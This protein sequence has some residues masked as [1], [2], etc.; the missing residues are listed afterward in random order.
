MG[1]MSHALF[2]DRLTQDV[3]PDDARR[4][5][6]TRVR[7]TIILDLFTLFKLQIFPQIAAELAAVW[8]AWSYADKRQLLAWLFFCLCV[9]HPFEVWGYVHTRRC[10][11]PE[12]RI[13]RWALF[14]QIII[15]VNSLMVAYAYYAF[16]MYSPREDLF[17]L[18]PVGVT[19]TVAFYSK[20]DLKTACVGVVPLGVTVV[21]LHL[22]RGGERDFVVAAFMAIA[23][24]VS[25]FMVFQQSKQIFETIYARFLNEELVGIL[26]I[27]NAEATQAKENAESANRT[28]TR[29]FMSASHDLRQPLHALLVLMGSLRFSVKDESAQ[30]TLNLMETALGSLKSLFDDLLNIARLESGKTSVTLDAVPV[31][32]LFESLA[33]EF[34]PLAHAKGLQL[35]FRAPIVAIMT[36]GLL[37]Q[38]ILRNFISNAIKYT[39]RGGVLVECRVSK[40]RA[41]IQVF[42][43]GIGIP[44]EHLELIF[45]DFYQ[46]PI[47]PGTIV[48]RR[49][50]VGLGLG[51][52]KRLAG[53]LGHSID[54]RSAPNRGS[55]FGLRVPLSTDLPVSVSIPVVDEMSSFS[56]SGRTIWIV[57]DDPSVAEAIKILLSHW[58]ARVVTATSKSELEKVSSAPAFAPDFLIADFQFEPS[59]SGEGILRYVRRRFGEAVPCAIVTGNIALVPDHISR[60]ANTYVLVKPVSAAELRSLLHF[61][62]SLSAAP[63]VGV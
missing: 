24:S 52:A 11:I 57:D 16:G 12:D 28:K 49:E 4:R 43:T 48:A 53:L 14:F 25:I 8:L 1:Y 18:L 35:R 7:G 61:N 58:N 34:E 32:M 50:G 5:L 63:A 33:S 21:S 36:D 2:T 10:G 38:R 55:T 29:F 60:L 51:I 15:G 13:E 41:A 9:H 39:N 23:A 59:F 19:L 54:V 42:D 47:A 26:K 62:L 46:I 22:L 20:A 45:D 3:L 37:L 44:P 30:P 17:L 56:L 31:V 6:I 27:K 40:G